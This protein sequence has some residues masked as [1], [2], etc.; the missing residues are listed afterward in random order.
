MGWSTTVVSPPD[1]DMADYMES[2][3]KLIRRDDA[4]LYPTHGNPV[5]E[6]APFLAAYLEHR[7][8]RETQILTVLSRGPSTIRSIVEELY[9]DVR[10][11]LHKPARRSVL[12]H[13]LKLH[14]EGRVAV[15][16]GSAVSMRA[17]WKWRESSL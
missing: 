5:R 17:T 2:V 3:R 6:P 1:G 15:A 8:E 9:V 14:D 13:M 10:R 16:D 4:I 7:L 12:S 11:E